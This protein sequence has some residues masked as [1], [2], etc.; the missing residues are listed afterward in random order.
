MRFGRFWGFSL[1]ASSRLKVSSTHSVL[2]VGLK[3][4]LP[5]KSV[6]GAT[7]ENLVHAESALQQLFHESF[8]Q[9]GVRNSFSYL[10]INSNITS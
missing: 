2:G 5:V 4:C 8:G 6:S 3:G 1:K 7:D 10:S 9:H